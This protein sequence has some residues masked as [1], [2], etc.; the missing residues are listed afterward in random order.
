MATVKE[1]EAGLLEGYL[2]YASYDEENG[3]YELVTMNL[4]NKALRCLT[5]KY[6]TISSP[7]QPAWSPDGSYLAFIAF[8]VGVA[9][10]DIEK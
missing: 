3:D 5:C 7:Q 2:T 9:H 6:N 8:Q 4:A 1:Y 10:H